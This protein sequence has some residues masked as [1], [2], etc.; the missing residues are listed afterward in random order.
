[1]SALIREAFGPLPLV[2][3]SFTKK[4]AKLVQDHTQSTAPEL[5]LKIY[6][7]DEHL[8]E[9][10][11]QSKES[12]TEKVFNIAKSIAKLVREEARKNPICYPS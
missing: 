9:R 6:E 10:I 11:R 5:S 7:I 2:S 4:T 8:L 1:M 12:D 3:R